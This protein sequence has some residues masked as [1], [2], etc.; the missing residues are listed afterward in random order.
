MGRFTAWG[1]AAIADHGVRARASRYRDRAFR[2]PGLV[3]SGALWGLGNIFRVARGPVRA[4]YKIFS[5]YPSSSHGSAAHGSRG[6]WL[7]AAGGGV[8]RRRRV[9]LESRRPTTHAVGRAETAT[10]DEGRRWFCRLCETRIEGSVEARTRAGSLRIEVQP[11]S[12]SRTES[13]LLCRCDRK[14]TGTNE[15]T[16]SIRRLGNRGLGAQ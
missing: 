9:S 15:G 7:I 3:G 13:G 10:A 5:R 11:I 1:I 12:A 6:P 14:P 8:N 4:Q 2:R 16:T